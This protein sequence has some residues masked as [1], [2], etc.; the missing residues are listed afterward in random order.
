MGGRFATHS[1]HTPLLG[2]GWALMNL[3]TNPSTLS[4][5][6]DYSPHQSI[7][8]VRVFLGE[9]QI[10]AISR[11]S[12]VMS[13]EEMF[14][15]V[16]FHFAEG[17]DKAEYARMSEEGRLRIEAWVTALRGLVGVVATSP[18]GA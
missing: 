10:G 13:A 12:L 2:V 16:E 4:F 15:K 9:T 8:K 7:P 14:P 11:C 6:L 18:A 5:Q 3:S 1:D 17:L